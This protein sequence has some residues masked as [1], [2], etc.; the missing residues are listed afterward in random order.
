M[1]STTSRVFRKLPALG[2]VLALSAAA[3]ASVMIN[4]AGAATPS[5]INLRTAAGASV[6]AGAGVSNTGPSVLSLDVDTS[7]TAAITGFPPGKTSGTKHGADAVALAAQHDL[8]SAYNAAASATTTNDVTGVDLSGKTLTQGVYTASSAMTLNGPGPLTLSGTANSVFIF[9]A[10]STLGTGANSAVRLTGGVQACNVY[11]Q[12]GASATLGASSVFAGNILALTSITVADGVTVQGRA[13]ARN[14]SVTL[15]NDTF[16]RPCA[17]GPQ[18]AGNGYWLVASDGG[19]FSFGDASFHG[20]TGAMTL[21]RPIVGMAAT[22]SGN[23]Y[24]LV[25]SDG[26]IFSFG[27]ASFHGSTGA[28][29]LNRPIVGMAATPSGNGYWLVASDGGIFS[30]GDASF[31]GSTG[32]MALNR[33][34]VGMAATQ[35]G[36]GY[37]LVA[38]DGGIFSFGDASFH[39][40]TGSITLNQPI[41][42]A[43]A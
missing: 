28:M 38:S 10:G 6:L 1:T 39:G 23:G 40:S 22:P 42:G 12:V 30:F 9:Q 2:A 32:A 4:S 33:P 36:N 13:L 8:T 15:A 35:S 7:P 41:V 24:W 34:I 5:V 25:A 29:T 43:A 21:N 37:W 16:T 14:G 18:A 3:V 19:I 26:G 27:D 17:R 20:S 11:W 31:H